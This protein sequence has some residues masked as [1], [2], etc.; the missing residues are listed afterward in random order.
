MM[1]S[2]LLRPAVMAG[3]LL[4]AACGGSPSGDWRGELRQTT[5]NP[6]VLTPAQPLVIPAVLELP[7]PGR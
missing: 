4:L 3:L 6:V 2:L 1:A 7:P 5:P